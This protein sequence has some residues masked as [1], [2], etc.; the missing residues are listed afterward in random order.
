MDANDKMMDSN[1]LRHFAEKLYRRDFKGMGLSHVD[2]TE[3][4]KNKL[5]SAPTSESD[6]LNVTVQIPLPEGEFYSYIGDLNPDNDVIDAVYNNGFARLGL[7][8]N[9]AVSYYQWVTFQYA[10]KDLSVEE[11]FNVNNWALIQIVKK[12]NNIAISNRTVS[13]AAQIHVTVENGALRIYGYSALARAGYVPY[14]FRL[15]RKRNRYKDKFIDNS[16]IYD[17]KK[18]CSKRI[19]W[20]LFGSVYTVKVQN[21]AGKKNVLC[22]SQSD[23]DK[24]S[25]DSS[26]YSTAP[27]SL[28]SVSTKTDEDGLT[29]DYVAWGRSMIPMYNRNSYK[30]QGRVKHRMIKLKFA[31]AYGPRMS[32]C[33]KRITPANMV[34]SLAEFS[35]VYNPAATNKWSFGK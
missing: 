25:C 9:F 7:K 5:L 17:S 19:G 31:I 6:T 26:S 18:Y 4:L 22:F 33:R 10:G 20:N 12:S 8:I 2:F 30:T 1:G 35:V 3:D 28:I 11:F 14:L 21:I 16:L 27:E 13:S 23:H 15:T 24:L 34:S 32:P 29:L